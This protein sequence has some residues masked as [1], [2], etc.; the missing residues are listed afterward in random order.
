MMFLFVAAQTE[1]FQHPH[2]D[3]VPHAEGSIY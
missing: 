2:P 1:C 3:G